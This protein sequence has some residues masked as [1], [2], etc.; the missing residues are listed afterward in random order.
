[1]SFQQLTP[2]SKL[3][4]KWWKIAESY[5]E[6]NSLAKHQIDS[7]NVF[8]REKLPNIITGSDIEYEKEGEHFII[9]F[10]NVYVNKPEFHEASGVINTNL[11]PQDCRTRNL[12]YGCRIHAD[13]TRSV[14]DK[15]GNQKQEPT[16]FKQ[17]YLGMIPCMVLS[18]YC[19]LKGKDLDEM[20]KKGEDPKDPGG[21]F[22]IKGSEKVLMSQDRMA[23]NEIFVFASKEKDNIK[24]TAPNAERSTT[25]ACAWSAEVR[26]HSN[27]FEPN[28]TT[29]Y[30]KLS[31][32][33]LEKGEDPRLYVELPGTKSPVAWPIV[34]KALGVETSE[35]M[36]NY[37]CDPNDVEMV[38]L[39]KPSLE[40]P[41]QTQDE[42]LKYLKDYVISLQ[43]DAKATILKRILTCS[44]FQNVKEQHMKRF[45]LG[46]MTFQLLSTALG[47]RNQDDRDHYSKKR[48]DTS[49]TLINN[50]FK[51]IWKRVN[52]EVTKNLN[53]R[54]NDLSL[55]FY[56]KIT[57]YIIPPFASGNWAA[58]KAS[59]NAKV[60]ISQMLNRHNYVSTISNLRRVNTPSDKNSKII[61]P[62]HLHNSQWYLICPFET[63]E[64]QSTGLIKNLA[65][66]TDMSLGSSEYSILDQL[67][68]N[69]ATM[70]T[71][72]DKFDA[73][74]RGTKIFLNG[75]WVA[76]TNNASELLKK[77]SKLK[78]KNII[79]YQTSI[80]L[81]K[82]GIRIYTDE[83]R[84]LA[85][86]LVVKNGKT[87]S[88][89][90]QFTWSELI[91]HGIIEYLD[92]SE[93]ETIKH[94]EYPWQIKE[95]QYS[96]IHPCFLFG[97][98]ASTPPFPDHNQSP[99]NIY[100]SAMGK[101]ALGVFSTNY[102][103]RLGTNAH[104]LYYPQKPI[105][106]TASMRLM[107]SEDLA[108][109][110]NLI[111]AV[112]S[113][114]YNQEDSVMLSKRAID[115]GALR[116]VCHT[117]YSESCHRKGNTIDE[118]KK[119]EKKFVK[120]TRLKGYDRLDSDG[121]SK[122][123]TPISKRDVVV[124]KINST[125]TFV[126]DTSVVVQTNG[127]EENAVTELNDMY[128]VHHG[129]AVVDKAILTTNED[130]YRTVKVRVRQM[131]V[132]QIG[133]K[134]ASRSAQKGII[135]MIVPPEDM[136]FS[137]VSGM[138]PDLL[139]NPNAFPSRMTMGQAL[140]SILGKACCLNGAYGDCT[141]FEKEFNLEIVG[142]E[143]KK[144]GFNEH[145]DEVFINGMTGDRMPCKIFVG[146]TYYQRLK[147]MVDDKI[148][149]RD[150][151]G[152][153]ETLTR[154]PVEGRKR[155]GGFR[156]GEME[157]WCGISHGASQFLNDRLVNNSDG[158]EMFVCNYCGNTAIATLKTNRFDCKRC[159]QNTK[160]SKIRIPYAFKLLM[161][162][163]QAC[164][165]GVWF[166][167]DKQKT[168]VQST[169]P[170][171]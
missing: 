3:D 32:R 89:P 118:I 139:M 17:V 11:K 79:D 85:P 154:Q 122:E 159:K 169:T 76:V 91:E 57:N 147:H 125:T 73:A 83:G 59:K 6:E 158:Y 123:N 132:P 155:G 112:L 167:V 171:H 134:L 75:S 165:I 124:G 151:D 100:Q 115:T 144:Y 58:S 41:I 80:S 160:I 111:V 31:R 13:I 87:K 81:S 136:P 170:S 153:R 113:A 54:R 157:T 93:L 72:Y 110:E 103:H 94:A 95:D 126:R 141:P 24:V 46:Q 66:M 129:A 106:N 64:G 99:R 69:Q 116:S 104:V 92:A 51:S 101:Q 39:L 131:R 161:Q 62:R 53:K 18:D 78:R 70:L 156:M 12:T 33:Q 148:H 102:L 152:P 42:A 50:L 26:S 55:A 49:G 163:L 137:E 128:T 27:F 77:L 9:N 47:R 84:L 45:Y 20:I 65:M 37:V 61:K 8:I 38:E 67:K 7:Y 52:R 19:N 119:P 43:K 86:F 90:E 68:I 71:K 149:A 28:I 5:F 74:L 82:E 30:M 29:T 44:L 1:M 88:L 60:G 98:S 22:I 108:S 23:H 117:T 145:G 164:G 48:V 146:P 25:L 2:E 4:K 138:S 142:E 140:E 56:G 10:D 135:G 40:C 35:E 150:Q 97:V 21:Y 162:E 166:N 130:S 121:V 96:P 127:M 14:I 143:L 105:V 34:F 120:E 15:S 133:D 168:L 109:G 107:G 63:P 16:T 36:I 114:A